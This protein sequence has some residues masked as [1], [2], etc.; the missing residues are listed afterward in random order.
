MCAERG[1]GS[2]LLPPPSFG[3]SHQDEA[4]PPKEVVVWGRLG[5]RPAWALAVSAVMN[6]SLTFLGQQFLL[7]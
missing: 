6:K 5:F 2:A 3:A 7:L 1:V 4:K